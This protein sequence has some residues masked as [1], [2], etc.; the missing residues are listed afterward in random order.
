MGGISTP[1][2]PFLPSPPRCPTEAPA[3]PSSFPATTV[4]GW[5]ARPFCCGPAVASASELVIPA[6]PADPSVTVSATRITWWPRTEAS[7]T[8][9][10]LPT[11]RTR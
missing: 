3:P 2:R 6:V 5:P 9:I 8:R 1:S 11:I 4:I 7:L 10:V